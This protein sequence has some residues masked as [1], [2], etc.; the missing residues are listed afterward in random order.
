[1]ALDLSY[2]RSA[3]QDAAQPALHPVVVVGAGP[4][5]LSLAID[6]AQR[7]QRVV[8]LDA[9]AALSVGSRAI[10]F[11]KRTLEIFDAL[12]VGEAMVARGVSWN[13]GRVFHGQRSLYSFNL[14]PEP[15]HQRPAFINLQQYVVEQLLVERAIALGVD[16]RWMNCVTAVEQHGAYVQLGIDTPDGPYTLQALYLAACDGARSTVR[17]RMGLSWTGRQFQDRFLIADVRI[18]E[19]LFPDGATERWFWFDPPFHPGGSV[20][21]HKQP[22]Y[23]WRIDFQLGW[24]ADPEAERQPDAIIPR[25]KAM[26]KLGFGRDIPFS[27]EWASVYTFAC[28]RMARFVHG[29]VLF[30]GDAAHRVSPFGARGANSG[31]QDADNLGWKLDAVLRGRASTALLASYGTEREAAA[32]EN[33]RNS[34]RSTDFITP[35]SDASRVLRDAVLHLARRHRFAQRLVNS[36]RLSSPSAYVDSPLSTLAADEARFDGGPV[37]GAPI[38]DA[39]L[40]ARSGERQ[41]LLAALRQAA[42]GRCT[43]LLWGAMPDWLQAFDL[44][45]IAVGGSW[46]DETGLATRRFDA[47]PGTAYLLRPDLHVAARWRSLRPEQLAEALST[48]TGHRAAAPRGAVSDAPEHAMEQHP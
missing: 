20:L 17:E 6:L 35:K 30:A 3:D 29:R 5:G 27:L 2:R 21:L 28:Q 14:L 7:G 32:D 37:P 12:G 18:D 31:I 36:G 44:G 40:L 22:G 33:L 15:G 4:V 24:G 10:C 11:A 46:L 8:V 39:P 41:W 26:L 19:D 48:L 38:A 45:V 9:D 42:R 43:L 47:Q 13:V 34:T 25:V 23:V 1:M 16:L